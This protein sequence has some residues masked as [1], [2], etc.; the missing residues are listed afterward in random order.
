[1]E[2]IHSNHVYFREEG[3][4]ILFEI[5]TIFFTNSFNKSEVFHSM[6]SVTEI[7]KL[8]MTLIDY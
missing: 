6:I 7:L 3:V 4:R 1:M 8:A 5:L 2:K